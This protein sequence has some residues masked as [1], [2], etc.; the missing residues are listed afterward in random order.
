MGRGPMTRDFWR[1]AKLS[2][3]AVLLVA[4]GAGAVHLAT[5]LLQRADGMTR[6][7]RVDVWAV[8]Q[9]EQELQ[10]VKNKIARHVAGDPGI[11]ME[12][13]HDQ[14]TRARTIIPLLRRGPHYEEFRL[15]VDIDGAASIA[16]DALKEVDRAL[17]DRTDFREDLDMLRRVD[18]LLAKPTATLGQLAVDLVDIR[19]ELQ[20]SDLE[21]VRWLT[22]VNLWMLIGFFGI[23]LIFIIFLL[24]ETHT[25]RRAEARTEEARNRLREAIESI[26]EGFVLYDAEDRLVL[27]NSKS[28]LR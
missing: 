19:R 3:L 14:L 13:L 21:N 28:T 6:Y 4:G 20:D 11:T 23:T 17:G 27:C 26:S 5:V 10:Q 22:G 12:A 18:D 8:Q 2:I 9:A 7:I 16:N 15:L 25:A 24:S 1:L